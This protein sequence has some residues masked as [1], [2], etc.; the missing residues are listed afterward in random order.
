MRN[1]TPRYIVRPT[2]HAFVYRVWDRLKAKYISGL[3]PADEAS[4]TA[5]RLNAT[6][7]V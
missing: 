1:N 7:E 2:V 4:I 5:A 6:P 3:L